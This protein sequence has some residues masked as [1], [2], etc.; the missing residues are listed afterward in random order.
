M[1]SYLADGFRTVRRVDGCHTQLC[2]SP[3]SLPG[4]YVVKVDDVQDGVQV[5]VTEASH[6]HVLHRVRVDHLVPQRTH[7]HVW[8]GGNTRT[9][10]YTLSTEC[11]FVKPSIP[12]VLRN[13]K[14]KKALAKRVCVYKGALL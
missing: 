4:D 12:Q 5:L 3:T 13:I 14:G 9:D 11:S 7:G 1:S 10:T 6:S 2:D 8:P